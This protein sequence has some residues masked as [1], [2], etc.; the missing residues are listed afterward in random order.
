MEIIHQTLQDFFKRIGLPMTQD[1]EMTV[2]RLEGLHGG[3]PI[4][5]PLFRT[6]YYSIL[7]ITGGKSG[8]TIDDLHYH[9]S[10]RL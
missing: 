6:N 2:H 10:T 1:T 9:L 4:Q 8:Y 7:L 3:K 5:S